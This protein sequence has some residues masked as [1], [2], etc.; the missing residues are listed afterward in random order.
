MRKDSKQVSLDIKLDFKK[1][2]CIKKFPLFQTEVHEQFTTKQK[3]IAA[4]G[5]LQ[6]NHDSEVASKKINIKNRIEQFF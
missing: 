6:I 5:V 4:T 3:S 2:T 1:E